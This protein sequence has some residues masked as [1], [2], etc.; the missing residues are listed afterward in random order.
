MTLPP[1]RMLDLLALPAAR[2]RRIH[3]VTDIEDVILEGLPAGAMR[4]LRDALGLSISSFARLAG[5]SPRSVIAANGRSGKLDPLV[6]DRLARIAKIVAHAEEVFGSHEKA[7][8]W[9]DK[10]VHALGGR[11]P[12]EKL[13]TDPGASQV[14]DVLAAIEHGVYV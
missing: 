11:R 10:P 12:F 7:Q 1:P 5:V 3:T 8:R 2:R 13:T 6:S 9:L 14:E 4:K